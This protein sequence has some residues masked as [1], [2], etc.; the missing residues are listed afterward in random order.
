MIKLAAFY[1]PGG[2]LPKTFGK[3][4]KEITINFGGKNLYHLTDG[5]I[6]SI[7]QNQFYIDDLFSDTIS[8]VSCIVG[9]NGSGK[10]TLL[11]EISNGYHF[12]YVLEDENGEPKLTDNLEHIHRIHYTPYLNYRTFDA[13]RNNAKDLSKLAV[14]TLDN[15]GDS[16]QLSEF[17]DAHNSENMKRWIEFNNFYENQDFLKIPLPIFHNIEIELTHFEIDIHKPDTF[18]NTSYQL[19]PA[20]TQLFNKMQSEQEA[21]EIAAGEGKDLTME[22]ATEISNLIRFEYD[23]YENAL[24]KFVLALERAGN[25]YLEE[26][27]IPDDFEQQIDQLEVRYGLQWFFENA[28]VFSGEEKYSFSRHLMMFE[29][30]DY[31][32][33]IHNVDSITDNWRKIKVDNKQAL[34]I[35]SLYNSFNNS[36]INE[37]LGYVAAPMFKLSPDIVISSGEQAFLNLFST[38]FNHAE[39]IRNGVDRDYHSSDSLSKIKSDI[40]LLLD[41]ADNAFHPQ[42]KKE[43]V[44]YLREILPIVFKGYN[45]QIIITSH[46]PLTLSDFPKNNVVFL[47]K[48][49]ETTIIGNANG[50]KTF[51]ANIAELLKDSFFMSDGQIGSFA[52]Q[53]IDQVID[54]VD[55][56]FGEMENVDQIQ[57]IIQSIDEPI[58]RFKLAEMLSEAL[59]SGDFEQQLIDQEI[60]RLTERKGKI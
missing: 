42:W 18:H 39:N 54:R 14:I 12:R 53:I 1:I 37:W 41:E 9:T 20:I 29:M 22:E 24:G 2:R 10:T 31:L 36:F 55:G 43:Y 30:I 5:E 50:K 28:G 38:L 26:G 45:I 23:L 58:I 57:R 6:T 34:T 35:L 40:F 32:I 17:L 4:H 11:N 48:V 3:G 59:G 7:V 47:E 56:G 51:G 49:G 15:H 19:R 8:L 60:K 27:Y 44:L 52:T 21:R 33:S 16:G 46:D 13:V 25:H